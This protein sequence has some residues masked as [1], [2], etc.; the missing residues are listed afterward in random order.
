MANLAYPD[1]TVD[2]LLR[3]AAVRD[4]EGLAVR[5][6]RRAWTFGELDA[7]ADRI[8]A[9]VRRAT[10]GRPGA[11]V[12][13]AC[14]LDPVFAAAYHGVARGGATVVL[15][16]PLM[17]AHGLR[18]VLTAADVELA[19]VPSAVAGHLA[20]LR[21]ALPALHT[22]VVTDADADASGAV[23]SGCLSLNVALEG[24]AEAALGRPGGADPDAVACVQFTTGTTG[25]PKGVLLTHRNLVANARQTALAHGLGPGSVALNHLPLYHV[26][27]LNSA[28]DAGACQVLCADP[29]PVTSLAVAAGTGAT[30]YYGLPARLHR[31]AVDERLPRTP[32][33][34]RGGTRLT[35]VLSG[36]SALLP[37]AAHTL[38]DLLGVPVEQ[39]Y[40]MAELSPLTHCRRPGSPPRPGT[41]GTPVPGTDCR[42][43]D[44][45]TRRPVDA[46]SLGEVQVRGP[47]LMAGYLGEDTRSRVD[48]DGWF[49]TGDIGTADDDGVL[50][51]VDRVDD[52]FKYD[53]EIVSPARVERALARDPRVADCVVAGLRDAEHGRT[54]W[55]GVVLREDPGERRAEAVL[56]SVV[57]RANERLASF[58]HIRAADVLSAVPRTPTGKPARSRVR[59][60]LAERAAFRTRSAPRSLHH[61]QEQTMVTFVNKLTVHGDLDTFLS[62]KNQLTAY[63]AAQPGYVSHQVM[64]HAWH[65]N[66][67][68]ELAVWEDADAHQRAVRSEEFQALVKQLGPL[69][70]PE[71]GLFETV[72]A[73]A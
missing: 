11:R 45:A 1:M 43:V 2:G 24:L 50:R 61:L 70:T 51:L 22:V 3:T 29:D 6:G 28:L 21:G 12:G 69:A 56:R 15:V 17:G 63:M 65:P 39:G 27:H 7:L 68:L 31:L 10:G 25:T 4:P 36:G 40:G 33:A 26:M 38:G 62:V 66:V 48:A 52:I 35:A 58:E 46:G 5:T 53:N 41:V 55:A 13:V 44:L 47:Q 72:E 19:L 73:S 9:F 16:N 60:A 23:P 42:L 71:P 18:H 32:R 8:A 14:V 30:H 20:G 57:A 49:S 54:A 59:Q 64:R 34:A 67:Y 37:E